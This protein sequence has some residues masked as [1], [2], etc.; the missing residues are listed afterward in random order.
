MY[1]RLFKQKLQFLQQINVKKCPSS[2]RHKDPNS[3]PS[4]YKPPPL[5]TRPGLPPSF[6][7]LPRRTCGD[8]DQ[9][10]LGLSCQQPVWPY[11]QNGF[12]IFGHLEQ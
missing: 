8:P 2:I 11:G 7:C 6:H 3:Q 9:N 5:T 12:V 10:V 1:F 4:D